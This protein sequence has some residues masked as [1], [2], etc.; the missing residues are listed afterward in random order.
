MANF[1]LAK[2]FRDSEVNDLNRQLS[3]IDDLG[4]TKARYLSRFYVGRVDRFVSRLS[5]SR[6][7]GFKTIIWVVRKK[8]LALEFG[9]MY[10]R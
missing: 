3:R 6:P 5:N 7:C 9:Y 1:D 4:C 10:G 2:M 8:T